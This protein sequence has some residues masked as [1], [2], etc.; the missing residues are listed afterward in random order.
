MN[1]DNDVFRVDV[2]CH[3]LT[4]K[5]ITTK[6]ALERVG[7]SGGRFL[8]CSPGRSLSCSPRTMMAMMPFPILKMVMM[9][10]MMMK[11]M[12][13]RVMIVGFLGMIG[14]LKGDVAVCSLILPLPR[15]PA[16]PP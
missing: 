16:Y 4:L 9:M 6:V 2:R 12:I 5:M 15:H 14:N 3:L 7:W 13:L 1:V 8:F 11:V 10:A